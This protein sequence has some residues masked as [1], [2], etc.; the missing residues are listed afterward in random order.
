MAVEP[1]VYD[2][3]AGNRRK[4]IDVSADVNQH[5]GVVPPRPQ[6]SAEA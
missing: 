2:Y 4:R 3:I 5:E 1:L 6:L